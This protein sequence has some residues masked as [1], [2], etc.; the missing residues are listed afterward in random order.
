[1]VPYRLELGA[2]V[3]LGD[4]HHGGSQC[5][6]DQC[7]VVEEARGDFLATQQHAVTHHPGGDRVIGYGRQGPGDD[8]AAVQGVHDL[9]ALVGLDEE[10]ADDGGDNRDP[11]QHQRIKGHCRTGC[12]HQQAAEQHGGDDRDGIGLE[13]VGG[14]AGTVTDVV[15]H[16]VGDHCRVARVI[17][18]DPGLHLADDVRADIGALGEDTATESGEDGDQRATEGQP[19]QRVYRVLDTHQQHDAIETGDTDQAQADDQHSRDGAAAK[20][21]LHGGIDAIIGGLASAHVGTHRDI[22]ADVA[23]ES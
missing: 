19:D 4:H 1:M 22:H 10:G 5:Q 12:L 20:G 23:G 8:Q 17:F 6:A 7:A 18:R 14:H 11:A 16:V 15:T 9:A 13:Q 3:V 2:G 21:D